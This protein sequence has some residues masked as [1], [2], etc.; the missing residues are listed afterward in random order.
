MTRYREICADLAQRIS[1][2][3]LPP[4]AELPGVR[5]LA[6]QWRTTPSTVSRAQ[7]SLAAAGVLDLADR[8]RA[9]VAAD[10][11]LAARRFLHAAAVFTLAGSDDPALDVLARA[12]A[13]SLVTV[14]GA[15]SA[16]G[17]GAVRQGRADGA[18]IHLL[19]H[20]GVYNAPF[21]GGLLRGMAP[22]LIRL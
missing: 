1:A 6:Q 11:A 9:R 17:L 8:R 18:T 15:G 20:T 22:H 7:R 13:G 10:A 19:H 2:G 4:G 14:T 5:E 3:D 16:A 21:A 12:L